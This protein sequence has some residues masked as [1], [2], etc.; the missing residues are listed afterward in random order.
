MTDQRSLPRRRL[1]SLKNRASFLGGAT[2]SPQAS[3]QPLRLAPSGELI[4]NTEFE[5]VA[6]MAAPPAM[7]SARSSPR[8]ATAC[9]TAP[10][11][12]NSRAS[13]PST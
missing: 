11:S 10:D 3:A 9:A 4:N 8:C 7:V 12:S 1:F 6:Q 2:T 5:A 13:T